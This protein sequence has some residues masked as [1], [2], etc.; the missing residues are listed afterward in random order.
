MLFMAYPLNNTEG[1]CL[2]NICLSNDYCVL[3]CLPVLNSK[4]IFHLNKYFPKLLHI[5][6]LASFF[7]MYRAIYD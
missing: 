5:Y 4:N 7:S 3:C 1:G 2:E 6:I